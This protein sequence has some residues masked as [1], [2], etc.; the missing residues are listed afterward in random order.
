METKKMGEIYGE[1]ANMVI[2]MIP[3][4]WNEI[5]LYGEVLQDSSEVYF[6]FNSLT[7]N[8]I[9]YG[10]DIPKIYSI[11][12]NIYENLLMELTDIVEELY[13][14]YKENNEDV[15]TNFTFRLN[16]TGKFSIKFNYDDILKSPFLSGE[17]QII[18]EY[19]VLGIEPTNE[20]HKEIIDRYLNSKDD[21]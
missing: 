8:N 2:E 14:E 18:W 21:E 20:N 7:S 11:D 13:K 16:N 9:I 3:D 5:Y 6:Y 1:I 4:K 12:E 17:R 15:W 10:H 19:E